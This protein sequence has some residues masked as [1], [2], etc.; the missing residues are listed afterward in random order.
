VKICTDATH[1]RYTSS[2]PISHVASR[3]IRRT[4]RSAPVDTCPHLSSPSA[5]VGPL[6]AFPAER[7]ACRPGRETTPHGGRTPGR[8]ARWHRTCT[9][10]VQP[11]CLARRRR[12]RERSDLPPQVATP[13]VPYGGRSD[14]LQQACAR[15]SRPAR[16]CRSQTRVRRMASREEAHMDQTTPDLPAH[17][18]ADGMA[19]L[20]ARLADS[21][22]RMHHGLL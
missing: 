5:G 9:R 4:D 12:R 13:V 6:S 19:I 11:Q 14:R 22:D 2:C 15:R 18:R 16:A 21:I 17:P 1:R 7:V 3:P 20:K 8:V 10:S